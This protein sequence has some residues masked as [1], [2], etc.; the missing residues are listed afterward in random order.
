M[1]HP[2]PEY[3]D[4]KIVCVE[5]C[6]NAP[7]KI[8]LKELNIAFARNDRNFIL[9]NVSD[10]VR[11]NIV[12]D[13]LLEGKDHMAEALK[14][15]KDRNVIELHITSIVTHGYTASADG[16][17]MLENN[18]RYAFSDVYIFNSAGKHAKI[19]E[20]RSYVIELNQS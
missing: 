4:L 19:K 6:E 20:I 18:K 8:I 15:M 1:S 10:N 5:D 2:T 17:F 14:Q 16:I 12:G 13:K 9:E 11:W 3:N 7:K